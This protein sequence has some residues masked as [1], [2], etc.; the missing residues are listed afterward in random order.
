MERTP[1]CLWIV[2]AAFTAALAAP[3]CSAQDTAP[4]TVQD[5]PSVEGLT[6]R[7]GRFIRLVTDIESETEASSLVESFDAAVPQW[8]EFWDVGVDTLEGWQVR[9]FVMR[10]RDRFRDQ[11]MIPRHVPDFPFGYA[12][13]D[14]VWVLAQQSEYYT[15]H[16]LLHEGV[17]S[18]AFRQFGGAGPT[19]YQEGTAELLATH[20]GSGPSVRVKQ[21]PATRDEAPYWGRFKLMKQL[22][23]QQRIPT[24]ATVMRYQ[25]ELTGDV[26]TY[27][28]SWA[29]SMLLAEYPDYRD[30]FL[31]AARRGRDAGPRFNRD[32]RQALEPHW[33]AILA[34]WR[35][36]CH[37][38]D[39]GFD[40]TRERV[41]VST[42]D[43]VWS[44]R[45]IRLDVAADRG[46]QSIGVRVPGNVRVSVSPAGRVTLAD[47]P[48]PW[49]SE[50]AGITYRFH[51]GRPIGQLLCCVLPNASDPRASTITPP[52]VHVVAQPTV[53]EIDEHSWLLFRINDF[54]GELADNRGSYQVTIEPA[55]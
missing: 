26:E 18:F 52:T 5:A 9:A 39:Y 41:N 24:L 16:L 21:I 34:R 43:R 4:T 46:W 35:M 55:R 17:H 6:T 3:P 25:A 47:L 48:K 20:R 8:A 10:D 29:A 31:R 13:D 50:P 40:W 12:Y 7:E 19:W 36:M 11:G 1:L 22:R 53:L 30:E 49:V 15:R 23:D 2:Y 33:P 37:D 38:L 28:W 44:G 42:S 32:L 54:P 14:N 45:P 27:G 51:R